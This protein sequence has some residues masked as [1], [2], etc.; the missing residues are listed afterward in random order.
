MIKEKIFR[1]GNSFQCEELAGSDWVPYGAISLNSLIVANLVQQ[2][3]LFV[4]F[5]VQNKSKIFV[6]YP[7]DI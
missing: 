7:S 6:T 2:W 4:D 3:P 5:K 1:S